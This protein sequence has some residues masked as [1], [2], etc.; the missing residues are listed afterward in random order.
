[1]K[2]SPPRHVNGWN[3]TPASY[4]KRDTIENNDSE[5]IL[6]EL[7]GNFISILTSNANHCFPVCEN[8]KN[9]RQNNVP[10]MVISST[11]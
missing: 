10:K 6:T 8:E 7:E 11:A 9:R 3:F 2:L 1:M 4:L 5:G